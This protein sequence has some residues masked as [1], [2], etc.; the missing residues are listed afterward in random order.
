VSV[1]EQPKPKQE[2]FSINVSLNAQNNVDLQ[3]GDQFRL[4]ISPRQAFEFAR[5]IRDK[6]RKGSERLQRHR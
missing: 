6:A 1:L 2:E 3:F 5:I 4:I